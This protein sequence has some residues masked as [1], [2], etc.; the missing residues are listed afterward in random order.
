MSQPNYSDP[1]QQL[2]QPTPPAPQP[3]QQWAPSAYSAP[4]TGAYPYAYQQPP[5]QPSG[6]GK[7]FSTNF[8][9]PIAVVIAKPIMVLVYILA[10]VIMTSGLIG[11]LGAVT[12][13]YADTIMILQSIVTLAYQI[14]L[15]LFLIGATR[16]LLDFIVHNQAKKS[17]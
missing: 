1:N 5:A 12:S 4:G 2:G 8:A 7:M 9:E 14:V 17:E 6:F 13:D 10:G 3:G 15:G 16:A 11:F